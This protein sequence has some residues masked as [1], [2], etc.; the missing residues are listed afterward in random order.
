[1]P[2]AILSVLGSLALVA[3]VLAL[4]YHATRYAA[5]RGLGRAGRARALELLDRLPLGRNEYLAVV[6]V[7][8][9]HLLLGIAAGGVTLLC[10]LTEEEAALWRQAPSGGAPPGFWAA[11][12]EAARQRREQGGGSDG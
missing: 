3:A 5:G 11:V 7:S 12:Q 4:A 1:M 9:R 6:R 2:E 10:E 8:T